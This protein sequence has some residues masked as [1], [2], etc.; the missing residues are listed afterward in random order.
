MPMRTFTND[1]LDGSRA[2]SVLFFVTISEQWLLPRMLPSLQRGSALDERG[3]RGG[4]KCQLQRFVT[5]DV[6]CC[7]TMCRLM[8][9]PGIHRSPSGNTQR[10]SEVAKTAI[11]LSLLGSMSAMAIFQQPLE[12]G[13]PTITRGGFSWWHPRACGLLGSGGQM[14]VSFSLRLQPSAVCDKPSSV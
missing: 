7:S 6:C 11:I 8:H 1:T 10:R 12:L 13:Q 14:P 2:V 9:L 4:G 5:H 3:T